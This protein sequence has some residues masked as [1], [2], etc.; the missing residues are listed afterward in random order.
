MKGMVSLGSNTVKVEFSLVMI[1]EFADF[2]LFRCFFIHD[3][4][5]SCIDLYKIDIFVC[6]YFCTCH[7]EPKNCKNKLST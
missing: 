3:C 5:I 7:L 1:F 6:F 4:E 2:K